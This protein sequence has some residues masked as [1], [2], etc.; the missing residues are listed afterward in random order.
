MSNTATKKMDRVSGL[1]ESDM[2]EDHISIMR[3]IRNRARVVAAIALIWQAMTIAAVSTVL[4]CDHGAAA[5][6]HAGM[7]DC[8]LHAKPACPLHAENH[9]SHDCDCP[10]IGCSKTDT[11]FTAFFGTVGVL[12]AM[13]ETTLPAAA[14]AA[15]P[16][17]SP[18]AS[19]LAPVPLAPPPRA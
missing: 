13:T 12:P 3:H 17:I 10:T 8:P 2:Q 4:A 15:A 11:V 7:P 5:S 16:V 14:S 1:T 18:S 6:E 9:G 19:S